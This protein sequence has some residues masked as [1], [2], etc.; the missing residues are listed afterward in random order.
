MKLKIRTIED[1]ALQFIKRTEPKNEKIKQKQNNMSNKIC[2]SKTLIDYKFCIKKYSSKNTEK[3][4]LQNYDCLVP[5]DNK[6]NKEN[7]NIK[8]SPASLN[9]IGTQLCPPQ[10]F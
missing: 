6:E 8:L 7:I 5:I 10:S 1:I 2:S 9:L 3:S 4:L